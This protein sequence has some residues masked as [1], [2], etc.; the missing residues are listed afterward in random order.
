[1]P[2]TDY[3]LESVKSKMA[4]SNLV[5]MG[6]LHSALNAWPIKYKVL[7]KISS[8]PTWTAEETTGFLTFTHLFECVNNKSRY[9]YVIFLFQ[10]LPFRKCIAESAVHINNTV[11]TATF[12]LSVTDTNMNID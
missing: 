7:P 11:S 9:S 3:F 6:N 5:K 8:W 4:K 1:M 10:R 2:T 12:S